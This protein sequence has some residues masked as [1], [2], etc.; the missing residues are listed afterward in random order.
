MNTQESLNVKSWKE[1]CDA[2]YWSNEFQKAS[3]HFQSGDVVFCKI[4]EVLRLF[5]QLRLTRRR[6]VL[7][8]G[9]GD[10]PCDAF[11]Q[12][13]LPANVGH[14]FATNV[15]NPHPRVTALPLGLGSPK[16]ATTLKADEI[17]AAR[18]A[19]IVRDQWLYVNFRPNTNPGER[20]APFAHFQGIFWDSDWITFE[21]PSERGDNAE[22]LRQ[23][24]RHRFVLCPP[25][26]GVDAHRMWETLLAGAIPVVKRS[27]AMEPF[28][29][30]PILFMDDLRD[31]TLELLEKTQQELRVPSRP[32]VMTTKSFWS[33]LIRAKQTEIRWEGL[34]GRWE[35]IAESMIYGAGMLSR[36]L[37]IRKHN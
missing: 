15:T 5:E 1:W 11:R 23:L 20:L 9:E 8:T 2:S 12:S 31:V 3:M 25:G 13:F 4:D 29:E 28:G 37:R 33:E 26:N 30:L 18:N 32:H 36:R 14:W 7:V 19:G 10:L 24:I 6:I 22:F 27:P 17:A 34:M 35:W 21:A 16:S